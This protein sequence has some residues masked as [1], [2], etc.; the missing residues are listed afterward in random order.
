MRDMDDSS[1]ASSVARSFRS[2]KRSLRR[3]RG[4]QQQQ[5]Q[6]SGADSGS[7]IYYNYRSCVKEIASVIVFGIISIN[8]TLYISSPSD[9]GNLRSLNN[10]I[11]ID[12]WSKQ[13][14]SQI[15]YPQEEFQSDSWKRLRPLPA[16]P[17]DLSSAI[18]L[19][20]EKRAVQTQTQTQTNS[21]YIEK[22]S[23][24][25][26]GSTQNSYVNDGLPKELHLNPELWLGLQ[27]EYKTG[28]WIRDLN[29]ATG[30]YDDW[31]AANAIF[32][33]VEQ[34]GILDGTI[35]LCE[36]S[37]DGEFT[38][39]TPD[40]DRN[41][42]VGNH[43]TWTPCISS[44]T[45]LIVQHGS[46]NIRN[47]MMECVTT[48]ET[49]TNIDDKKDD[50]PIASPSKS[51][52]THV[53]LLQINTN[54]EESATQIVNLINNNKLKPQ[55]VHYKTSS[56]SSSSKWSQKMANVLMSRGY[57]WQRL[58][59]DYTLAC[60][61]Q[62]VS[63]SLMPFAYMPSTTKDALELILDKRGE[64]GAPGTVVHIGDGFKHNANNESPIVG[65]LLNAK[66]RWMMVQADLRVD[67][68]HPF[69]SFQ[70][71][72]IVD[73]HHCVNGFVSFCETNVKH[74]GFFRRHQ[75]KTFD[76]ESC[77]QMGGNPSA[78][79]QQ[80]CVSS[81]QHLV[82]QY[83]GADMSRATTSCDE[84]NGACT[85]HVDLLIID[86]D[87]ESSNGYGSVKQI[88]FDAFVPHCIHYRSAAQQ[89]NTG[90]ANFLMS[91][92]YSVRQEGRDYAIAC[93]AQHEKAPSGPIG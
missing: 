39:A 52:S 6:Q 27:V 23:F 19:I 20:L 90:M 26:I 60:F 36:R 2:V 38:L 79:K 59:N 22:A 57:E 62:V 11:K 32:L 82:Q 91:R 45:Q 25:K 50:K 54:V 80:P 46:E 87:A 65:E 49:T 40:A 53:D 18:N 15:Q 75:A 10:E 67:S 48:L 61:V 69:S 86:L 84:T 43:F 64:Q 58:D 56:S 28:P 31:K 47:G 51:C 3:P 7:R 30:G 77:H 12:E 93:I 17:G 63:P 9:A 76:A 70:G 74:A 34:C 44:V 42:C 81:L 5:Q 21:N 68:T 1:V 24:L 8:I 72:A 29:E 55:C 13:Q 66:D 14:Q 4:Q 35:A 88:I 73:P 71:G 83:G 92:G 89:Q 78:L 37:I 33:S 41:E 16:M 85:T